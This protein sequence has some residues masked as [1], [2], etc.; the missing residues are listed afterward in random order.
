[1]LDQ[2]LYILFA[3]SP[4]I[5]LCKVWSNL[6]VIS[7]SLQRLGHAIIISGWRNKY[8]LATHE[9]ALKNKEFWNRQCSCLPIILVTSHTTLPLSTTHP[10]T[11]THNSTRK[12]QFLISNHSNWLCGNRLYHVCIIK[13]IVGRVTNWQYNV[14]ET[15]SFR[16]RFDMFPTISCSFTVNLSSYGTVRFPEMY[17]RHFLSSF[18]PLCNSMKVA[19]ITVHSS[20]SRLQNSWCHLNMTIAT[21][22]QRN[23]LLGMQLNRWGN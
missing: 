2:I 13:D 8:G 18:Y 1:M 23:L 17:S 15:W 7:S 11:C 12:R 5:V 14:C 16:R 9:T 6:Y 3:A 21:K 10:H 19:V 4:F 22:R 20:P